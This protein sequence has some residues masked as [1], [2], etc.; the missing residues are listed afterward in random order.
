[1]AIADEVVAI[2]REN[3]IVGRTRELENALAA[4][5]SGKHLMIEGPVGVGK[6]ILAVAAARHLRRPVFRV[7]GDERYTEQKLSGWF[8]PPMVMEKGYVPE[9]F[10]PGPLMSAMREGGVLF[11]N[12]MNRMPEGVQNILLPA[13]DEGL[14][15]VPKIGTVRARPGFVVIGTQNPR[16]FV[17][18]TAISEALS[19]RFELLLLDYQSEDE[20]VAIVSKNLPDALP[21]VV[22][23]SVWIARRTRD[24]P[25]IRRGASV[26]AA[27]SIAQ[28]SRTFSE[29]LYEGIR[30]AAHM[31]LPTR[32]EMREESK[33][34]AEQVVEEIVN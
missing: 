11:I 22:A 16:E 19:D 13:M 17:A 7:D 2:Q 26:R 33:R 30:K 34:S 9:A 23:R 15:E 1:M 3:G 21:E 14:I 28:L 5:G 29:D 27:M 24:H 4:I 10:V 20:E 12:E 18:T 25:N 31:A 32:I 8:D 6:T